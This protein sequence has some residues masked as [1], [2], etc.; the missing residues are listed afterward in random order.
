MELKSVNRYVI[1][2]DA[3]QNN[4]VLQNN[5]NNKIINIQVCLFLSKIMIESQK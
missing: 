5:N 4:E 1:F 3:F 2:I